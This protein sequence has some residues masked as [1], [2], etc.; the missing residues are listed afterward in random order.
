[1]CLLCDGGCPTLVDEPEVAAAAFDPS[2]CGRIEVHAG[3]WQPL[4]TDAIQDFGPRGRGQRGICVQCDRDFRACDLDMREVNDVAPDQKRLS[5]VGDEVAGMACSV[6]R[7]RNRGDAWHKCVL[8]GKWR[9][10]VAVGIE[11]V[12]CEVEEGLECV[13]SAGTD[14]VVPP[15]GKF[16]LM[17]RELLN[18]W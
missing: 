12:S 10:P 18:V 14:G 5:L 9:Q 3:D 13:R 11:D 4:G 2:G 7:Q 6:P 8:A 15:K 16:V 1:M 17:D